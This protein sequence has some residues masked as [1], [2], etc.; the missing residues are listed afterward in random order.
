MS[1]PLSYKEKLLAGWEEAFK[2]SQVKLYILLALKESPKTMSEI[3]A[4]IADVTNHIT[5][6]DDKSL[7]R[8]LRQYHGI[9][10]VEYCLKSGYRG[11][12]LKVYALTDS[13]SWLLSQFIERNI[14]IFN[15][16]K[17]LSVLF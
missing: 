1:A 6:V 13:G 4:F 17:R 2:K 9:S 7:Y 16:N 12:D 5:D 8:A 14:A 11:P 3:K 15:T 10:I